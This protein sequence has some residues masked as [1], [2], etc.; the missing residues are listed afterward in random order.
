[1]RVITTPSLLQVTLVGGP[2]VEV[3]VRV[4]DWSSNVK[5]VTVGEPAMDNVCGMLTGV[6]IMHDKLV[7]KYKLKKFSTLDLVI[8]VKD[9]VYLSLNKCIVKW[10]ERM[11]ILSLSYLQVSSTKCTAETRKLSLYYHSFSLML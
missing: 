2:P 10:S 11:N 5:L 7:A 3:Q 6:L 9:S 1:M 4:Q 8:R